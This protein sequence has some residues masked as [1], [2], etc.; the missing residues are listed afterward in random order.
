[1]KASKPMRLLPIPAQARPLVLA[2]RRRSARQWRVVLL[3]QP[4][5]AQAQ[6]Q[7]LH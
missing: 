1:L 7:A 2:L 3:L 4:A 5:Q 6:R